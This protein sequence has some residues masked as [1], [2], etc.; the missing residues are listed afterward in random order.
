MTRL[1]ITSRPVRGAVFGYGSIGPVHL[2][3][4]RGTDDG[5]TVPIPDVTL[6]A[7]AEPDLA[8][9]ARVPAGVPV[10]RDYATLLR[11]VPIEV[12]HICLPHHL[13][14]SATI[15][16]AERGVSIICEKP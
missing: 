11:E 16:A 5:T 1:P 14:A 15:A 8:R 4:V 7:V 10:I 13:H 9:A 6:A 12:A 2:M 3:S